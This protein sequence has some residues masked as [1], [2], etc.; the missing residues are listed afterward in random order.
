MNDFHA[1]MRMCI[2]L[3]QRGALALFAALAL[4][5]SVLTLLCAIG[6]VPWV[7]LPLTWNGAAVPAAGLYAQV[8]LT[9]FMLALCFFLPANWRMM[10]LEDSHR[11]FEIGVA[12]ITRAYHTAHAADREGL[13]RTHDAFEDMRE[14][15]G[16]MHDHPDLGQ[17]EPELL[18]LAA[19]MSHISRD[20]ADAYSDA[21]VARA[22][23]FLK[24]RQYEV[25]RFKDRLAHA[26]A[27]HSE[28]SNWIT[29]IE[30]DE[31]VARTQ[32]VRLLDELETM[33]PELGVQ[34]APVPAI[35]QTAKVT[36]LPKRAE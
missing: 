30:L 15:I 24:E 4:G 12:D 9:A 6:V 26:Q 11:R 3:L 27:I 29:R 32:V 23:S 14:R 31:N 34:P 28:F 22:R 1:M 25:D 10:R 20:L 8:G 19:R 7:S 13:F 17:L 33:L 36:Q 5:L 16:Y 21:R 2:S 18:D 35:H